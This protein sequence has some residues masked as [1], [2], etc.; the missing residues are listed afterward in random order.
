MSEEE[1]A[2]LRA[3]YAY[4]YDSKQHE[5]GAGWSRFPWDV[6]MRELCAIKAQAVGRTKTVSEDFY[7]RF[8]MK[9]SFSGRP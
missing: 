9:Q 6:A 3:S 1:I 2:R 8:Y 4:V 5:R 7:A